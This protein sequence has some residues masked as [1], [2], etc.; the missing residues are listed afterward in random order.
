MG[1]EVTNNKKKKGEITDVISKWIPLLTGIITLVVAIGNF[2]LNFLNYGYARKA[3]D[4]YGIPSRYFTNSFV[5][6]KVMIFVSIFLYFVILD[7]P[8]I[9]KKLYKVEKLGKFESVL[10]SLVIFVDTIPV[11][12]MS[13]IEIIVFFNLSVSE[14][15]VII[16]TVIIA[17]IIAITTFVFYMSLFTK[18][19]SNVRKEDLGKLEIK[20]EKVEGRNDKNT[21]KT[22]KS[23]TKEVVASN[24]QEKAGALMRFK[25]FIKELPTIILAAVLTFVVLSPS[26][27]VKP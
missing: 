10:Y 8:F 14:L 1:S 11:V 13:I 6:D 16:A 22:K 21:K 20:E 9:L 27:N 12:Y 23:K 7:L 4:F 26:Y 3:E 15:P 25:G 2:A 24:N 19:I 5:D 17:M 18:D